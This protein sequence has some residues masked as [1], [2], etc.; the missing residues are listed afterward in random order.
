MHLQITEGHRLSGAPFPFS[1]LPGHS[2]SRVSCGLGSRGCAGLFLHHFPLPPI[3]SKWHRPLGGGGASRIL[4]AYWRQVIVQECGAWIPRRDNEI[5]VHL[6]HFCTGSR[7]L[8]GPES[9]QI[10]SRDSSFGTICTNLHQSAQMRGA[11]S[12][13]GTWN[14]GSRGAYGVLM[15]YSSKER[16]PVHLVGRQA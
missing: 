2:F 8:G 7:S 16:M 3:G 9:A 14:R 12:F 6:G 15:E 1:V 5:A 10:G 11:S 4:A 13:A